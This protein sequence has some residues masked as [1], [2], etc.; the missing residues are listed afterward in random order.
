[1]WSELGVG[2]ILSESGVRSSLRLRRR[3]DHEGDRVPAGAAAGLGARAGGSWLPSVYAPEFE[4][5][6][7]QHTYRALRFL[8]EVG[9]QLEERLTRVLT[10]KLFADASLVL[11]DTTS[12]YFE[13][14]GPEGLA[15]FGYSRDKRGDRPQVNL[16][17]LTSRE[18][19]PLA[20]WLYPGRQS[21]VRSMALASAEFRDRL[22]LGSFVVVADR[23]MV[24]AAN[25]Q[26]LRD[27]GI[28]YV[29]AERLRQERRERGPGP[30]RPVQEGERPPRGQGDH[31][32]R[33]TSACSCAATRN[34]PRRTPANARP[35]W[36]SSKRSWRAAPGGTNCN[37]PPAA[38]SRCSGANAEIDTAKAKNDARFDGKWVLR[39]TTDLPPEQ[40]ALAYRGLWRVEN[41]FRTLKTPLELRPIFHT[42]EAG[43]RGHVQACVLAYTLV[44]IMEDRLDAAGLDLNA[45][46]ALDRLDT[47]QR[48][49][50]TLGEQRIERTSTPDD[51]QA[52]ILHALKA[53]PPEAITA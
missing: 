40:V 3:D 50:I 42:S 49:T 29:I 25:L 18:G 10:E 9:P 33:A 12:T 1:M 46:D 22:D 27:E 44:R 14:V 21:D 43:V 51:D 13:G 4:G 20:H 15:S 53:P 38:T 36:S 37:T 8:A 26:A 48:A 19:I 52:A 6:E 5:I 47:I 35:S 34:A 23:G 41:A 31:D 24:S 45:H 7:L 30:S 32:A 28:R 16:G 17:L 39:T 2:E 11:F